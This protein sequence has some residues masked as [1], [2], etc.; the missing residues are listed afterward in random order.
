V[1]AV[2]RSFGQRSVDLDKAVAHGCACSTPPSAGHRPG[3][4]AAAELT[5]STQLLR[6]R[7]HELVG[8]ELD[9]DLLVVVGPRHRAPGDRAPGIGAPR[10]P[11]V[12]WHTAP[13][14]TP[15][16]GAAARHPRGTAG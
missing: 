13:C 2:P 7:P 14:T 9:A 11:R 5:P 15:L 6:V 12:W 4:A 3:R 10:R 8:E 1:H 16:P